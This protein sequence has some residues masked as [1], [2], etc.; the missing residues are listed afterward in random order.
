M[1]DFVSMYARQSEGGMAT[2][3]ILELLENSL[4]LNKIEGGG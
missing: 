2:V 3:K 4:N 1:L